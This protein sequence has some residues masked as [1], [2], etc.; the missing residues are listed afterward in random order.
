M[1]VNKRERG[2][3]IINL[4]LLMVAAMI[5]GMFGFQQLRHYKAE[6]QAITDSINK[7]RIETAIMNAYF[8]AYA[9]N[10]SIMIQE[11]IRDFNDHPETFFHP[12][13]IPPKPPTSPQYY[14]ARLE[15]VDVVVYY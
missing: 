15:G 4:L 14:Q 1:T 9:A 12:D 10:D 11:I 2:S 8:S 6:Q 7:M 13:S 5:L 3:I